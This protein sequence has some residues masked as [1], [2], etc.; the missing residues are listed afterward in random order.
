MLLGPIWFFELEHVHVVF[1]IIVV[2]LHIQGGFRGTARGL[3]LDVI[4]VAADLRRAIYQHFTVMMCD[5]EG[6]L[7]SFRFS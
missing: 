3:Q 2:T 4:G 6:W 1:G 5:K 7:V